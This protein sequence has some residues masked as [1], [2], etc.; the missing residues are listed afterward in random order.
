MMITHAPRTTGF[1]PASLRANK[2]ALFYDWNIA[3]AVAAALFVVTSWASRIRITYFTYSF[4]SFT[5]IEQ[6]QSVFQTTKP[7]YHAFMFIIICIGVDLEHRMKNETAHQKM[8]SFRSLFVRFVYVCVWMCFRNSSLFFCC[9]HFGSFTPRIST[10]FCWS[11]RNTA[12]VI[13]TRVFVYAHAHF[14]KQNEM[15]SS[16]CFG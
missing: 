4:T 5:L 16:A 1:N 3:I 14:R 2:K 10:N 6:I 15:G 8:R 11:A 12:A 9:D 7:L 13:C